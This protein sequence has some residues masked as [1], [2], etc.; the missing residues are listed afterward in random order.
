MTIKRDAPHRLR[1]SGRMV[2][3]I[4]LVAILVMAGL[5]L[6]PV[7]LVAVTG[8]RD[9]SMVCA[10]AVR[11]STITLTFTHSMYGGDVIE[12]F[13]PTG[14]GTLL[15]TSILADQAAAAEYYAWDGQVEPIGERFE[16]V[17]PDQEFAALPVRVDQ[18]G[19]HRLTIDGWRVDLATMVDGS[20]GVRLALV[21]R[22]LATH[23]L[24]MG[25]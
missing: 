23:L 20:E 7:T 5:A 17:V 14:A 24:G 10:R 18:I 3:A 25:C 1:L 16:V 8:E 12:T 13:Q 2:A 22:P 15:R 9:R 19:A 11:N 21:T 6:T 4:G